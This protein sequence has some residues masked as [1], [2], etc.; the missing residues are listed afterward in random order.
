MQHI[1]LVRHG[2]TED[3]EKHLMQGSSDSPLSARGREEALRTAEA[4]SGIRLMPPFPARWGARGKQPRSWR[5]R[6]RGWK[7]FR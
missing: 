3:I 2:T 1:Y 7:L 6:I 5:T 4:L